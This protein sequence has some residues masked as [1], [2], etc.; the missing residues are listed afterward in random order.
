MADRVADIERR[1]ANVAPGNFQFMLEGLLAARN[2]RPGPNPT[3]LSIASGP[4]YPAGSLAFAGDPSGGVQSRG[5]LSSYLVANGI[6]SRNG[7]L[8]ED[9]PLVPVSGGWTDSIRLLAP[10]ARSWE[11]MRRAAAADGIDLRVIDGYRSWETQDAAHQAYLRGEKKARVL[12]AG[13]SEHGVGL[14]VD[15]TNGQLLQPGDREWGWLTR[16]AAAYGWFPL[17]DEPWHWEFRGT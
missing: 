16:H 8:P 10:A 15:L 14:A 11:T 9:G 13:T 4:A 7:R 3:R 1:M 17:S 6:R 5:A 12:P 2:E